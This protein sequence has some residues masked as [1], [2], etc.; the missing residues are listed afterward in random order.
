MIAAKAEGVTVSPAGRAG[1]ALAWLASLALL[2][3]WLVGSSTW[4]LREALRRWQFWSLDTCVLLALVSVVLLGREWLRNLERSDAIRMAALASVAVGVTLF[5]APRTNRIYYDEQ[6]YQSIGQ[7]LADLRL[8]QVCNDGSV[9]YGRLRCASGDYNKQPYGYPHLLSL[10]YRLFGAQ[11]SIAFAVNAAAMAVTVCGVYLLVVIGFRDREAA[12]LAGLLMALTPE[13]A[14]WCATA[15]VEP[16]ASAALV[17]ATLAAATFARSG[18]TVALTAVAVATAYAIQ[19]RPESILVVPVVVLFAWPR[20]RVELGRP[21]F[22][23]IGLLFLWL[24]AAHFGHLIAIRDVGWG[25]SEPRFSLGYVAAN[26]HVNGWFYLFDERFPTLFTA[27]AV[28]GILGSR[29]REHLAMALYFCLFFGTCLLFYAGSYNYGAD[30]RYSLMTYPPLAVLG[31]LGAA[32]LVA[33]L[34]KLAP[35]V[36]ARAL[37]LLGLG[38][39]FLWYAPVVRATT[40]EGWAARADVRFARMVSAELPPDS[41]VL[42]QNPGMF[43]LW[44][45]N[46]GQMSLVRTP[47]YV[48]FLLERYKGGVYVHWNFWCNVQD[49]A[50]QDLCRQALSAAP[51]KIV[52]EFRERDQRYA[53][54]RLTDP[55]MAV[56]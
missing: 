48:A 34:R 13:Q 50:Q 46:A 32:K 54:Y 1:V 22:R 27:L 8:A 30:V 28:L 2:A 17:L 18:S 5:I 31:G 10:G 4:D 44:G 3:V 45:T 37:V 15:A 41:Y 11:E 14:I 26:L 24:T 55:R 9:E 56:P 38:F 23:W 51:S 53:F 21:R 20:F 12:L 52:R 36:P 29:A 16:T 7:N 49:P 6:I 43:Q 42:T 47:A 19:F 40:E 25:T 33:T 39:Q 35:A